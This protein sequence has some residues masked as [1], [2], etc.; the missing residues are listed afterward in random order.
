MA[1]ERIWGVQYV[2]KIPQ[3]SL[4]TMR[5]EYLAVHGELEPPLT[6]GRVRQQSWS[7]D[8]VE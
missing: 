4:L 6:L 3:T 5:I 7:G 8:A 2:S 1:F